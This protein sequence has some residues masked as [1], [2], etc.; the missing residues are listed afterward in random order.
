MIYVTLMLSR[1]KNRFTGM[2]C[3]RRQIIPCFMLTSVSR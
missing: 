3:L 2:K 1:I